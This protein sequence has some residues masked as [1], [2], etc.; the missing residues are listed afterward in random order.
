MCRILIG[1]CLLIATSCVQRDTNPQQSDLIYRDL[2]KEL[3]L[4]SKNVVAIEL[5]YAERLNELKA[6]VP[7]TGQIK[8]YE[9]KVFESKN[10]LGRLQQQKLFF[11]ISLKQ[12]EE[13]VRSRYKEVFRGG[14]PWPDIKE[15]ETFEKSQKFQ[16][17][18]I[19]W[20]K[21]KGMVKSVPRGTGEVKKEIPT[22]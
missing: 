20:E 14:R 1:L 18:K 5:E 4:V 3:D 17:E 2:N 21:N 8:S 10:N 15:L 16:R 13:Y 7:Q 22:H 19:A 12:R 6:V 11:E 9:K